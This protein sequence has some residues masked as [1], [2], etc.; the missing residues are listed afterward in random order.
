MSIGSWLSTQEKAELWRR[1]KAGETISGMTR[2]M[3]RGHLTLLTAVRVHGGVAPRK[4]CRSRLALTLAEREEISRGLIAQHSIRQ[5]AQRL[6]RAPS[7]I[8]REIARNTALPWRYRA[9]TSDQRAWD[10]A[11]RPKPCHLARHPQLASL[12]AQKLQLEWSPQQIAGWLARQYGDD[13]SMR[14]SHET[15]YKSLF[16]QARG[17]LKKQLTAHLRSG[18]ALRRG[19]G[20]ANNGPGRGQICDAV[21]IRE[22]PAQAEDR[23][24]PGHWEGD[25]LVGSAH[26]HIATL[27]ERKSRFVMLVKVPNNET[28]TVVTA[29]TRRIRTLPKQLRRSL[30][31]D[32]GKEMASHKDFS[33]A[34]DVKVY[35]CDP[36]SPWQRGSNEN[37]NGLLRQ[38]FPKK[39]DLSGYSQAH[40]DRIALRLN[41]RPRETL[42]FQTPADKLSAYVAS[43]H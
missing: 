24:V 8:S 6:R 10:R 12:V 30:T 27:V 28:K 5:I 43:I 26:S 16:I 11:L 33:L 1:W 4:R 21:S 25:L 41:Q 40:L 17:V 35:F 39:T 32:R 36:H 37:T 2:A 18:R 19:R 29:L 42:G 23:A 34:T 15:I 7:T 22:R 38:Y 31:W 13:K 9:H 20:Y 3:G 14:V